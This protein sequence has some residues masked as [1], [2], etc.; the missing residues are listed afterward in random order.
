MWLSKDVLPDELTDWDQKTYLNLISDT[1]TEEQIAQVI[2]PPA[3]YPRQE[4]VLALHWHPEF[5]PMELI[6]QRL[7]ATFPNVGQLL[8]IPTQHNVLLTWDDYAGVEVDCYSAAFNRKVQLLIHFAKDRLA[9]A[10]VFTSMLRHTFQYR[11]QQLFQFMDTLTLPEREADLQAAAAKTGAD[12]HLVSFVKVYTAKLK[13]LFHEN[14]DITS[15]HAIKNKLV[16]N[17]FD[18]LRDLY[19]DRLINHAQVLLRT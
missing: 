12:E 7:E 13:N 5:V 17:Y 8:I 6:R 1:L 19:D 3:T 16:R 15:D 10:D 2:E 11:S 9:R 14:E 18:A 4:A